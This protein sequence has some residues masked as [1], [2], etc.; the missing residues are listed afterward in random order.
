M[1][2]SSSTMKLCLIAILSMAVSACAVFPER[3]PRSIYHLPVS[4]LAG[5]G[6]TPRNVTLRISRPSVD[7]IQGGVRII[8][9]PDAIT[10]QGY[11]QAQWNAPVPVLLRDHLIDAFRSDGRFKSIVSD[12]ESLRADLELG[13]HLRAYRVEYENGLPYVKVLFDANLID[14]A[15]N[16]VIRSRRFHINEALAAEPVEEA[17]RAFWRATETLSRELVAWLVADTG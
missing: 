12:R 2:Y 4:E 9:S 3:E 17:V 15:E 8:V 7:D 16:R 5:S 1:K 10:L 11:R 6:E 14:L 13:G